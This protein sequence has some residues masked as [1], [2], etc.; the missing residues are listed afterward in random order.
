LYRREEEAADQEVGLGCADPDLER[1]MLS[2]RLGVERLAGLRI[3]RYER[4]GRRRSTAQ[5][6]PLRH[7]AMQPAV[8]SRA[9]KPD[10]AP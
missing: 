5:R 8:R 6:Q 2:Q 7:A 4:A 9:V 10:V 1:E 3:G